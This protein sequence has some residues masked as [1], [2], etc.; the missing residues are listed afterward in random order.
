MSAPARRSGRA[1]FLC[2]VWMLIG[3]E[4]AAWLQRPV[5]F[6]LVSGGFAVLTGHEWGSNVQRQVTMLAGSAVGGRADDHRATH[7]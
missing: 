6:T 7:S 4:P 2:H 5:T 3:I 1:W